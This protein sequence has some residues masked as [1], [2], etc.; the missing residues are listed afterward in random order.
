MF[1]QKRTVFCPPNAKPNP[2]E[3]VVTVQNVNRLKL[4]VRD[5]EDATWPSATP[6]SSIVTQVS[7]YIGLHN[8]RSVTQTP[9]AVTVNPLGRGCGHTTKECQWIKKY[10]GFKVL[11]NKAL[12]AKH[13]V[14]HNGE[15]HV[16]SVGFL[17][18]EDPVTKIKKTTYAQRKKAASK[19]AKADAATW[20]VPLLD[21][22]QQPLSYPLCEIK[23]YNTHILYL[24]VGFTH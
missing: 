16:V 22:S 17:K 4:H 3:A 11:Y 10:E 24:Q 6:K 15:T 19:K 23:W 9:S 14:H 13:T 2:N 7:L 12:D 5:E 1:I 20:T 21:G 18:S 8:V